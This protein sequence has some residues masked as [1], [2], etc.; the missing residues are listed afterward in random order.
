MDRTITQQSTNEIAVGTLT[1][2]SVIILLCAW[3]WLKNIQPFTYAEHYQ[4]KFNDASGL[5]TKAAVKLNGIIVGRV[6]SMKLN[7]D[8]FVQVGFKITS[9][10]AVIRQNAVFTIAGVSPI[11]A[12]S[13]VISEPANPPGVPPPAVLDPKTVAIGQDS[14]PLDAL[15]EKLAVVLKDF[16][17]G[18]LRQELNADMNK[19]A[20]AAD[21][22]SRTSQ[23]FGQVANKTIVLTN[24]ANAM[25]GDVAATAS[26]MNNVTK[27]MSQILDKRHPLM[28]LMLGRPGHLQHESTPTVSTGNS[29]ATK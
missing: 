4:V 14:V 6:E 1:L 23:K 21:S 5:H 20:T 19:M 13:L 12:K 26:Q 18:G 7:A 29:Q 15:I 27:Q 3:M 28:H 16:S 22:V 10:D 17:S 9:K 2:I 24:K 25:S 11:A 8:G